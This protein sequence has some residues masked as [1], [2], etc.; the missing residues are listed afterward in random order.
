MWACEFVYGKRKTDANFSFVWLLL[1]STRLLHNDEQNKLF[2]DWFQGS[3][4]NIIS[5]SLFSIY[6][7]KVLFQFLCDLF[8]NGFICCVSNLWW[9]DN[10][11]DLYIH[12]SVHALILHMWKWEWESEWVR[13]GRCG[14]TRR[15]GVRVYLLSSFD[16]M[17]GWMTIA[18]SVIVFFG[19]QRNHSQSKRLGSINQDDDFENG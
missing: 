9:F 5:F 19:S 8:V 2:I 17:N 10:R 14:R 6:I 4:V 16:S 12:H 11:Y 1:I 3:V 13:D 18:S 15:V 7:F